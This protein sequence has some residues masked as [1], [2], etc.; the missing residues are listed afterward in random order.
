MAIYG[1]TPD[2]S[3]S[4]KG[5]IQLAGDLAGTASTPTLNKYQIVTSSTRPAA[6][7]NGWMIY[8]TDTNLVWTYNSANA[9]WRG[10][11][12]EHGQ[13]SYVNISPLSSGTGN[14][15]I[16]T[17]PS[18]YNVRILSWQVGVTPSVTG[19]SFFTVSLKTDNAAAVKTVLTLASFTTSAF[20]INQWN[21]ST[22][23]SFSNNPINKTTQFV[24]YVDA[25]ATG[26]PGNNYF[27]NLIRMCL[28]S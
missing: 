17:V 6:P 25:V 18:D 2:A 16:T 23:T 27:S 9:E 15:Y 3:T 8:E 22:I 1:T 26:A 12:I 24:L 21:R 11:A 4:T 10:P 20:T 5:K 19:A 28:V 14:L 13:G 7:S